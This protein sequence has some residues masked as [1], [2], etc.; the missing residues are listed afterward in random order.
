[1]ERIAGSEPIP[2][3][4]ADS[5]RG[6]PPRGASG[7]DLHHYWR[8]FYG[9][10][11]LLLA[12]TLLGLALAA[13]Y[14]LRQPRLYQAQATV[15]FKQAVPPGKDMETAKQEVL[16]PP[17]LAARL[18]TTKLLAARVI[19]VQRREG[20]RWFDAPADPKASTSGEGSALHG[21]VERLRLILG[22][23]P[24]REAAAPG[25]APPPAEWEGVD[26]S[27]LRRYYASV[28]VSPVPMTSL[29]D[30]IVTHP[31]RVVAAKLAN[32]H[33]E[34]F[35]AMDVESKAASLSDAQSLFRQQLEEV[36]GKL[37]TSRAKLTDYQREHGILSLPKD[38]TTITRESLQ[39]LNQLLT[40][41]QGE[42]I[43]A[44]ANYRSAQERSPEDL[45]RSLPDGVLQKLRGD[46]LER[47]A[48]YEGNLREYG[49]NHPD[50]ATL[51][52]RIQSLEERLSAAALQAREQLRAVFEVATAKE[53]ELRTNFERLSHEASQEDRELI[54][55]LILQ[56]DVESNQQLYTTL[57]QQVK[58]SDLIPGAD[59]WKNVKLVDRA[60]VPTVASFPRTS[61][62][63]EL[64]L[65][66]GFLIGAVGCV[67]LERLDTRLHTPDQVM[68]RL[69]LPTYGVVPDFRRLGPMAGYGY[70]ARLLP[71]A[72]GAGREVVAP[73]DPASVVS[74]AY[75]SIR[76]NLLF[77][78]PAAPPKIVLV[79]S[80]QPDEGKTVTAINVAVSLALSGSRVLLVDADL[81]KPSC[82]TSLN[83]RREP[84]LSNVLTGQCEVGEAIV[85]SPL[86]SNGDTDRQNGHGLYI[87]P[88]G[89]SP[90]NPSEL[91]GSTVMDRLLERLKDE[92]E[93]V[94]IDSPPVL[95]V[96]DGV[97]IATK[98]DGVLL[99]VKGGAWSSDVTEKGLAQLEAVRARM[100]GI[101]LN[102][103]DVARGG[104]TY[105]YYRHYH[106]SYYHE[107]AARGRE[108]A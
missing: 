58:E 5:M 2:A 86:L 12:T 15:E 50:M 46:L 21:I 17:A 103:V 89:V 18:L 20:N 27:T 74:E 23:S 96:T 64:G 92:F 52:S 6:A 108:E 40:V 44:E 26:L 57:L 48:R 22:S 39:Q 69:Q 33:A 37:E 7:S 94:L 80:S 3:R 30:I 35:V 32:A 75:R 102:C 104:S 54:Q 1:M 42:R 100:L 105:Y 28:S 24:S 97:V 79:T 65:L 73:V 4:P 93:F 88:A 72:R 34:T 90:P 9:R 63:L 83:V 91:L 11:W 60:I 98:T 51:R 43:V 78:S 8:I 16:I 25:E 71:L 53:A 31:D 49:P 56:R 10:R 95:R 47:R 66:L 38:N 41:A 84:G 19:G 61:R 77:S 67:V 13:L 45:A 62:N 99:V 59:H 68:E 36:K 82:H 81:R 70:G 85:R 107:P 87:L 101:I 29:A 55:L 76:T 106:G 14:T